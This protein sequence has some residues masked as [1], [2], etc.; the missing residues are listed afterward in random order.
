MSVDELYKEDDIDLK[1]EAAKAKKSNK[2]VKS[3]TKKSTKKL[4][5]NS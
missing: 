1:T 5:K 4:S 2:V 3:K